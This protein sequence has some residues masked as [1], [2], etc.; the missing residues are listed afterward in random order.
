MKKNIKIHLEKEDK[1]KKNYITKDEF[2]C[3][4]DD[5]LIKYIRLMSKIKHINYDELLNNIFEIIFEISMKD[6]DLSNMKSVVNNYYK[7]VKKYKKHMLF[8]SKNKRNIIKFYE[9]L[10]KKNKLDVNILRYILHL[11]YN[12]N[13]LDSKCILEWYNKLEINS[14]FLGSTLLK[15]FIEWLNDQSSSDS[16]ES[17]IDSE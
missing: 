14:I 5:N 12:E 9:R 10:F 6:V 3:I 7:N 15:D 4:K 11:L 17:E 1:S 2:L 8:F 13:I 16:E